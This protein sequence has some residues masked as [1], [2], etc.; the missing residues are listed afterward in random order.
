VFMCVVAAGQ[1]GPTSQPLDDQ[2]PDPE[3]S[4]LGTTAAM[5]SRP[6][7]AK[8]HSYRV[9]VYSRTPCYDLLI[10]ASGPGSHIE[11]R[12]CAAR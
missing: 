12:S 3:D 2:H 1:T 8:N 9:K 7:S 5:T 6:H 10:V 11:K 4:P